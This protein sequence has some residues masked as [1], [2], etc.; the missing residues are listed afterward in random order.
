MTAYGY[1]WLGEKLPGFTTADA[2]YIPFEVDVSNVSVLSNTTWTTLTDM[3]YT[4]L[5]CRPARIKRNNELGLSFSNGE[6]CVTAP[7]VATPCSDCGLAGLYIQWY[8]G[9]FTSWYLS[10]MGCESDA[11][12]HTFLAVWGQNWSSPVHDDIEVIAL[13]CE[14][15]YWVQTA[16][17]TVEP[18]TGN[19][20]VSRKVGSPRTLGEDRFNFSNF[21]YVI[22]TGSNSLASPRADIPKTLQGID[23]KRQLVGMGWN[24][25]VE[26]TNMV[27]FALGS[28][29]LPLQDYLDAPTL[30]SSFEKAHKLLF[31]LAIHDLLEPTTENVRSDKA[32]LQGSTSA[33][34]LLRPLAIA[35]EI[36]LVLISILTALLWRVSVI[37][38]N[39]LRHDPASLKDIVGMTR[40]AQACIVSETQRSERE[41]RSM[42]FLREG[43]IR[44]RDG[45]RLLL[46]EPGGLKS[47]SSCTRTEGAQNKT[48]GTA[49]TRPLEMG[50][51]VGSSFLLILFSALVILIV[52]HCLMSKHDGLPIPA[53]SSLVWQL[54]FNYIPVA[55]ATFL[56]PFWTL[57]NRLLCM[58]QPFKE[59]L[60]GEATARRSLDVRYTSLP[61]Q[62]VLWRAIRARHFLLAAV[63]A[64][65]FG[66]NI[67]AVALGGLF[68]THSTALRSGLRLGGHSQYTFTEIKD[69]SSNDQKY[70]MQANLSG[71]TPLPPWV[72]RDTY[73][74]PFDFNAG[75]L[76]H[77]FESVQGTTPGMSARVQCEPAQL[78]TEA[79][80][81]VNQSGFRAQRRASSGRIVECAV[82]TSGLF[83]GQSNANSALESFG[84]ATSV[85]QSI[86]D[87]D[88]CAHTV[89]A[90]FVRANLSLSFSEYKTDNLQ[91]YAIPKI[92][93][94][95]KLE[96]LWVVCQVEAETSLYDVSVSPQ[97]QVLS[98][99]AVSPVMKIPS[100]QFRNGTSETDLVNATTQLLIA[101]VNDYGPWW[102]NDTF[103]DSW[104]SY[105]VKRLSGS[106]ALLDPSLPPPKFESVAPVVADLYARLFAINLAFRP[107]WFS[108]AG[109]VAD[110]PGTA[111]V[112]SERLYMSR[113]MFW[114]AISL[115]ASNMIVAVLYYVRRPGL[116]LKQMPS[117]IASILAT[118]D[119]S[120]I[121]NEDTDT[122]QWRQQ[123]RFGYGKFI[124]NDG[125]P[126]V[127]IER[128]PFVI[129]WSKSGPN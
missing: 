52:L 19:I 92:L 100:A 58:L 65:S 27:G 102:R 113:T 63:C 34:K 78:N 90:G 30:V 123:Y 68:E 129:P 101:G 10:G 6:A 46:P 33:L 36:C 112:Q 41:A 14:P 110:L 114:I 66:A 119:Q 74:R 20:I 108:E 96:A 25:S 29:R 5:P 67:L 127:G 124:G 39:E 97:G 3:Y 75:S 28:S 24:D 122:D 70:L 21:E 60:S 98:Y 83:G 54:I 18:A 51:I 8:A 13:F 87:I 85:S 9:P 125:K 7:G 15:T 61:P 91:T 40:A 53:V 77:G 12:K 118:F 43:Q 45:G 47:S 44:R 72:S 55:F 88:V 26:I 104:F 71:Q 89:V 17:V 116:F 2:A 107:D 42:W 48:G 111:F 56:E 115:L 95:N 32:L 99:Q 79:F 76:P 59:L 62:L 4:E 38:R 82:Q 11:N 109:P 16:N 103:A 49:Y 84:G 80:L 64:M 94:I 37:C 69:R 117:T 93:A 1:L 105:F 86:E 57:L 35:A 106:K 50:Y 128:K 22:G 120:G 126:H 81:D 23:Q 73:F 121:I 31:A